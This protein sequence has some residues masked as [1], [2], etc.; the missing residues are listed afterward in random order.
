MTYI[1]QNGTIII[2]DTGNGSD[3]SDTSMEG[4]VRY[5]WY[6][7]N[8]NFDFID[9]HLYKKIVAPSAHGTTKFI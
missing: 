2:A 1:A 8:I 9:N 5:E 3:C 7:N 4:G 6:S